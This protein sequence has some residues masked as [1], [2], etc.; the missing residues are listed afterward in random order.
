M[1]DLN[2]LLKQNRLLKQYQGT[3]GTG[4]TPSTGGTGAVATPAT[5]YPIGTFTGE[6]VDNNPDLP[7]GHYNIP[8][9][10]ISESRYPLYNED[11]DVRKDRYSDMYK[12]YLET[13]EMP[14]DFVPF[15]TIEY[16]YKG[17]LDSFGFGHLDIFTESASVHRTDYEKQERY[18]MKDVPLSEYL[19]GVV[20]NQYERQDRMYAK[21]KANAPSADNYLPF[22]FENKAKWQ[23]DTKVYWDKIYDQKKAVSVEKSGTGE[24]QD[25][26]GNWQYPTYTEINDAYTAALKAEDQKETELGIAAGTHSK[27]GEP[28]VRTKANFTTN[29]ALAM[30]LAIPAVME[31]TPAGEAAWGVWATTNA[32]AIAAAGVTA[33]MLWDKY[34][35]TGEYS[36]A[37]IAERQL[38]KGRF[39]QLTAMTSAERVWK[40]H[41]GVEGLWVAVGGGAGTTFI[42]KEYYDNVRNI[43]GPQTA[44][45]PSGSGTVGAQTAELPPWAIAEDAKWIGPDGLPREVSDEEWGNMTEEAQEQYRGT[46]QREGD[47]QSQMQ[48]SEKPPSD[49]DG[50]GKDKDPAWKRFWK[51]T[52]NFSADKVN[53]ISKAREWLQSQ[54]F[55]TQSMR[56][57]AQT[58]WGDA[59]AGERMAKVFYQF[60]GNTAVGRWVSSLTLLHGVDYL[61]ATFRNKINKANDPNWEETTPAKTIIG[62]MLEADESKMDE[63]TRLFHVKMKKMLSDPRIT[64]DDKGFQVM[65]DGMTKL[66]EDAGE[67]YFNDSVYWNAYE[68]VYYPSDSTVEFESGYKGQGS[69]TTYSKDDKRQTGGLVHNSF[70][71]MR[72]FKDG[73]IMSRITQYQ[74]TDATGLPAGYTGVDQ[75]YP[76]ITTP[77][78]TYTDMTDWDGHTQ[79]GQAGL[80]EY[81]FQNYDAWR[82]FMKQQSGFENYDFGKLP[83]WGE[84][85]NKAWGYTTQNRT[86]S[87]I[88]NVVN[89]DNTSEGTC[90]DQGLCSDGAGGCIPCPDAN[91]T[92]RKQ[93]TE[94]EFEALRIQSRQKMFAD[95]GGKVIAGGAALLP[96]WAAW[97]QANIMENEVDEFGSIPNVK[98]PQVHIKAPVKEINMQIEDLDDQF[99]AVVENLKTKGASA[100]AILAAEKQRRTAK[101]QL[102]AKKE[103]MLL[104]ADAE[105]QKLTA[106]YAMDAAKQNQLKDI[107]MKLEEMDFRTATKKAKIDILQKLANTIGGFVLDEKKMYSDKSIAKIVTSALTAGTGMMERKRLITMMVDFMGYTPE[108]IRNAEGGD[109]FLGGTGY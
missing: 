49:D 8:E 40:T 99:N 36:K 2:Q 29:D 30:V 65:V 72:Q 91:N 5:P 87:T 89:N 46:L 19:F 13:G 14:D 92:S 42:S 37:S 12:Q 47:S 23:A 78:S 10:K 95:I 88:S 16:G 15:G 34:T 58:S 94:E 63:K 24:Y 73:G 85:H 56:D 32:P 26:N 81:G 107:K 25:E 39:D 22:N 90:A 80:N 41:N 93:L 105:S 21:Q 3:S 69:D 102:T 18:D 17:D 100:S 44:E 108:M 62:R 28:A 86:A 1:L 109:E 68:S 79:P 38:M 50:G 67:D 103:D 101:G 75:A 106:S 59:M 76:S 53:K 98:S 7:A 77:D 104:K 74:G 9:V 61:Q 54:P 52:K 70:N 35:E 83:Y 33:V 57:M 84:K 71:Q 48:N 60:R 4:V 43:S 64:D 51:S 45:D 6:Q 82:G 11:A 66:V 96:T 55:G 97:N 20:E 31:P 27:P